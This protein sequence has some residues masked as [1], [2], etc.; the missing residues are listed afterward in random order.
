MQTLL[1]DPSSSKRP[2]K[3]Y[4]RTSALLALSFFKIVLFFF[5]RFSALTRPPLSRH[6]FPSFGT[7]RTTPVERKFRGHLLCL[8]RDLRMLIH[9]LVVGEIIRS[10]I[11]PFRNIVSF[12]C[13]PY[14]LIFIGQDRRNGSLQQTTL[15]NL[16]TRVS[17]FE[18]SLLLPRHL[19]R[20]TV[21]INVPLP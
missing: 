6:T 11:Y 2:R 9:S 19:Q 13:H 18:D 7:I 15:P 3:S 4:I 14:L 12:C 17:N 10:D 8:I 21:Q 20:V 5:I 1:F 16:M